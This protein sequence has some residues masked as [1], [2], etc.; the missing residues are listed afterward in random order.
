MAVLP[1]AV[2]LTVT[3]KTGFVIPNIKKK[4]D[5]GEAVRL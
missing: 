2:V 4:P 3:F 5:C 1:I